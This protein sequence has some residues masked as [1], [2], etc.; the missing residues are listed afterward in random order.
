[1]SF[2]QTAQI[3]YA[4]DPI[5][6]A[7]PTSCV[8]S[9]IDF[10]QN[11]QAKDNYKNY[12]RYIL[13][14]WG[15]ASSVQGWQMMSEINIF[16][17]YKDNNPGFR[18]A[19]HSWIH[20]MG[21]FAH[22]DQYDRHLMSVAAVGRDEGGLNNLQD[23]SLFESPHIDFMGIHTYSIQDH[24]PLLPYNN[25]TDVFR[26]RSLIQIYEAI[27]NLNMGHNGA[28]D[29]LGST[30][31]DKMF[32]FDEYGV[33]IYNRMEWNPSISNPDA[34]KTFAKY[35]RHYFHTDL[36]SSMCS[37]A[38]TP[39]LDWWAWDQSGRYQKWIGSFTGIRTFFNSIDFE[40]RNYDKIWGKNNDNQY[41]SAQ[42]HPAKEKKLRKLILPKRQRVMVK[43]TNRRICHDLR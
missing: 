39:G 4:S 1:M 13:S 37:G 38:A 3:S 14:R 42:R 10:F 11:P 30:L 32:I 12:M 19:V 27:R 8:T 34:Q 28:P 9:L 18:S 16:K 35:E 5:P 6:Q 43:M 29:T 31:L 2:T 15:Y 7:I 22:S 26:N 33:S 20:E 21:E 23:I 24:D 40:N 25:V 36:W 17:E 41:C